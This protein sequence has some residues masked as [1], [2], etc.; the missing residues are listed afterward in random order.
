MPRVVL[1]PPFAGDAERLAGV[2][3]MQHIDVADSTVDF[4]HVGHNRDSGPVALEDGSAM[5]V[6]FA[7]PGGLGS[8]DC[9]DGEV[10]SAAPGEQRASL[11]TV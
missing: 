11:C 10:E 9:V 1:A 5:L 7:H 3:A 8:E 4:P 2:A 6:C